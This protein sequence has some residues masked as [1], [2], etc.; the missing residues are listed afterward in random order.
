[1]ALSFGDFEL[2]QERRQLLRAGRPV[3]LEP[4]A[5]ELLSLL[6]ERRP[7]ALSRAQI[8]D[9]VWRGVFITESTL[10][11]AVNGIR[12]ALDDDA[13]QPRFIRTVHGFG[14]AFCG[15]VREDVAASPPARPGLIARRPI[16]FWGAAGALVVATVLGVWLLSKRGPGS[17]AGSVRITPLTT[18]GGAKTC[19]Q[20]SLDGE[21]V[22]YSWA[23]PADDNWD[24]YVK[25]VGTDTTSLRLTENPDLD[26]SPVWSPD[27]RQIAFMRASNQDV[28]I[29]TVPSL[30]GQERKLTDVEGAPYVSSLA[31][32]LSWSPDGKWLAF[33]EKISE[34][35][36]SHIVRL[37]L[38]TLERQALTSPPDR[39]SG[40]HHPAISPD[41]TL[42]AFVRER[43]GA[44]DVWVLGVERGDARRLTSGEYGACVGFAWT[45]DGTELLFAESDRIL[46]VRLAGGEPQ[47]V[48]GL[49][50]G[51][52][53]PSVQGRR[54]VHGQLLET[55]TFRI[56]RTPGPRAVR[57]DR[58]PEILIGSSPGD[59]HPVYSPD[60]RRIAFVSG[61]SGTT[62]VWVSDSDGSHPIQLTDLKQAGTPR[63]S[64]DGRR[65]VFDSPEAGD[66][67]LYVID[68]E[69]RLP[70]R[71]TPETS[72]DYRGTWSRDGQSIYFV[73]NR[74][75]SDQ[76]WRIP[77]TGGP[78]VQVTRGG[79]AYAEA[80][81]DD[82]HAY[83][84][85]TEF[86]SGIWRVPVGGGEATE[87][88]QGPIRHALDWAL[89]ATGIVYATEDER[90]Q[91]VEYTIRSLDI[92]SGDVTDLF[93]RT[94]PYFHGGLT[95]S[96]DEEWVLFG[97]GS[98]GRSDLMLVEG[99]R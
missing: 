91:V 67:N 20:L 43:S 16:F 12:Q 41:G 19:P 5:Y 85:K 26:W 39:T 94:G 69:G 88:V 51:A 78:A 63:W 6:L 81:W 96:P 49:G 75:G 18:D 48:A 84:A 11:V 54:M 55:P 38:D 47:L 46:R 31:P 27:G 13:R 25:A 62:N 50:H 95:V 32:A 87:V 52:Y 7:R 3:S 97:E 72:N 76:I 22:A 83:F 86:L 74:G 34:D 60:G 57:R 68:A 45:P 65:I 64:P 4:K 28:S 92:E 59:G 40:D 53:M 33:A 35:D 73:S 8:R 37:S 93:R 10:G 98:G 56:W 17:P 82:T 9:V 42:V 1:M 23:G 66:L 58:A 36:P 80:S 21:R 99:F 90:A 24:I 61:R 30:G 14:Y 77:S 29:F 15:E 89:S 44:C 2:D 79:A 71:L 70:R